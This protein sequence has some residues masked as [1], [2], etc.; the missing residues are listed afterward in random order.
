MTVYADNAATTRVSKEALD[1]MLPFL[2]EEYGNPNSVY[3][4][5]ASARKALDKAREQVAAALGASPNEIIFT[6][7][8]TEANNFALRGLAKLGEKKG[9]HIISS[10][11]EHHAVLHVL[12]ALEKE[13]FSYTLL[14]VDN[15]GRISPSSLEEAIRE[16]TC[17][18]SLMAANNEVG[19]V[20]DIA[21]FAAIAKEKG[22][23]FH[24]DAVQLIGHMPFSVKEIPVTALSLSGHKMYAPKG[25]GVLYLKNG[26]RIPAL[27]E[28]GGQ[29]KNRRSGTEN[30]AGAVA[31][32]EAITAAISELPAEQARISALRDRLIDGMLQIPKVQLSGHP[33][34]RLPGNASFLVEAV[35]GEALVLTLGMN[36]IAASSGSACSTASLEPSHVLLACAIPA[37]VAHGS[38]RLTLGRYNTEED[39]DTI[40]KTAKACIERLRFMSPVW[41]P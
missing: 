6:S 36:G 20:Q 39:V 14:P 28:G 32:G 22:I 1:A 38:L 23:Y 37:E 41:Q 7:G 25:I 26:V 33:T 18:I 27:L 5:G 10:A 12:K 8:G 34:D 2:T 21:A 3:A 4:L 11:I 31:L 29:E 13:G 16:D 40:I 15:K 30:V 9:R 19:T 24:T 35:E 17:C